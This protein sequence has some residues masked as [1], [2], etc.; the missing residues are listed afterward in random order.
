MLPLRD[1]NPRRSFP[2]VTIL[3]IGA[4]IAVFLY[5]FSLSPHG[6][7]GFILSYGATPAAVLTGA[8]VASRQAPIPLLTLFT[9]MFLHGG[10]MHLAGNMLYLW[11]FGDNVEDR[12]GPVR[13]FAFYLSC[14]VAAALI[15]ILMRPDSTAPMVGASGAIAGI[16]GA[17]ALLYPSARVQTLVFLFIF[18]RIVEVPALILLGVWFLMQLLAAPAREGAGVAFFA[19]IGGFLTGMLLLAV[20]LRRSGRNA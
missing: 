10:I 12:M 9:S 18:V 20:F 4:N 2:A 1:E 11:I 3:L 14:G 19:H 7:E 6:L 16:L 17:Y 15:Q 13:F 8:R 5:E